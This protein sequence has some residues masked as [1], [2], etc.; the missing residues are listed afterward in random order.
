MACDCKN[1]IVR[2]LTILSDL[3][4]GE[5]EKVSSLIYLKSYKRKKLIFLEES[6][7][8][9]VYIMK[10]GN[11]KT[12]KSLPDGR[13]QI[14]S[15]LSPGEML[16]FDSLYD[17]KYS[18]TA[19]VIQDAELCCIKKA[20]L[21]DLL[22][23][24]PEVGMKFIKILNR[25]LNRA[26]DRIRDLGLKDARERVATLLMTL[27]TSGPADRGPGFTLSRQEISEM[28]GVAQETVI[29]ILSEFK[30]DGIIHTEGRN[31]V[32]TNPAELRRWAGDG[33]NF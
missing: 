20:D 23:Q 28:I 29:R 5:L 18:S 21:V 27:F 16:G 4:F 17:D 8:N 22:K 30:S 19:E 3:N 26:Q 9:T 15:I 33:F 6:P 10:T 14:I 32:I 12:Y 7:S 13:E 2:S 25:E 31:I 24:N 1:C 11:V